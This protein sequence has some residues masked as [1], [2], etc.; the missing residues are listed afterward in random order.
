MN[1][2][3]CRV[4]GSWQNRSGSYYTR[5]VQDSAKLPEDD[6]LL[7]LTNLTLG[8]AGPYSCFFQN[9]YGS[10]VSTGWVEVREGSPLQELQEQ[11]DAEQHSSSRSLLVAAA[12]ASSLGLS[13]AGLAVFYCCKFRRE[14]MKKLLAEQSAQTVLR[15]TNKV[16]VER[17]QEG[18]G[19]VGPEVRLERREEEVAEVWEQG[20]ELYIFPEDPGWEVTR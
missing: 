17:L 15:W 20:R 18:G 7:H 9:E 4:D 11:L 1:K 3:V 13:L 5:V 12:V 10:A 2:D 16:I 14:R 8:D 19:V 6:T